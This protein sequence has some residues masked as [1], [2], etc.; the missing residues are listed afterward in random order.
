MRICADKAMQSL[1]LIGRY[2]CDR[3][4][5]TGSKANLESDWSAKC[6][7]SIAM[8]HSC[9]KLTEAKL[10]SH[11]RVEIPQ[12]RPKDSAQVHQALFLLEGGVWGRDYFLD[13]LLTLDLSGTTGQRSNIARLQRA[14]AVLGFYWNCLFH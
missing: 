4:P 13:A 14:Q 11:W 1:V 9:G 10:R 3:M 5:A 2:A 7:D 12:R 8:L 6:T